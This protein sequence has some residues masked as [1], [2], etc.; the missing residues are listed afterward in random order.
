MIGKNNTSSWLLALLPLSL[1]SACQYID[2][3]RGG[4]TDSW[5]YCDQFGCVLCHPSGCGSAGFCYSDSD[6]PDNQYCD[7]YY[8]VCKTKAGCT[9]SAEC[10]IGQICQAGTCMPGTFPCTSNGACG[11]GGYC[12]NGTCKNSGLCSKDSDCAGF[13]SSFVCDTRGSCV[14][15]TIPQPPTC[16]SGSACTDGLCLDGSCGSCSGDC[17]GA[18]TCQFDNHCGTGRVCLDAQCTSKC[19]TAADCGSAQACKSGV[20]VPDTTGF[21]TKNIDCGTGKACLNNTCYAICTG[22]CANAKDVCV[23][24]IGVGSVQTKLC[25]P[26]HAAQPQCKLTKDCTGGEQCVNGI[27]RTVCTKTEDCAACPAGPVCGVGGFC[28][29]AIENAPQCASSAQCAG[30]ECLNGQ[31]TTL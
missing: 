10:G 25:K 22:T 11:A 30:K 20:C 7:P 1:L 24:P 16:Q 3:P 13:G 27:C 14:P 21:C 6:C 18:A 12:S 29:T 15:S 23:D 2:G 8:S 28:M 19:S 9:V 26:N 4:R 17:G 31:C 5:Y